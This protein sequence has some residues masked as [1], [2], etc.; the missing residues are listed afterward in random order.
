[1]PNLPASFIIVLIFA[2]GVFASMGIISYLN[3]PQQRDDALPD[4]EITKAAEK[5]DEAEEYMARIERLS[6]REMDEEDARR[7]TKK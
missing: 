3:R 1:M 2:V 6:R 5:A 4:D 7:D